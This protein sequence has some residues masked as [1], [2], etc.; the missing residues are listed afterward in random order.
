MNDKELAYLKALET[1][2]K[3]RL[4]ELR[5]DSDADMMRLYNESGVTERAIMADGVRVGMV[6]V[7]LSQPRF[8][9][10]DEAAFLE[11]AQDNQLDALIETQ[12]KPADGWQ[13]F[14]ELRADGV[15]YLVGTGAPLPGVIYEPAR[16]MSPQIRGCK[17]ADVAA[18]LHIQ[19]DTNSIAGFLGGGNNDQ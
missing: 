16:P 11:F 10:I 4:K 9:I 7:P 19:L 3:Q 2:V 18:A 12:V 15:V 17:P 5:T 8:T 14:A 13:D 6:K 1:A